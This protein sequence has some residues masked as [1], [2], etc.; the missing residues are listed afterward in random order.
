MNGSRCE[1]DEKGQGS[2]RYAIEVENKYPVFTST[3]L[4][5]IR[6]DICYRGATFLTVTHGIE[7]TL[8]VGKFIFVPAR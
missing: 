1:F 5:T 7:F 6:F 8:S 4:K 2:K 3:A